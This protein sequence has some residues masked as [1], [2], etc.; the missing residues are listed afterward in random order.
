MLSTPG[1]MTAPAQQLGC[2]TALMIPL[3]TRACGLIMSAICA[4]KLGKLHCDYWCGHRICGYAI[5]AKRRVDL[6]SINMSTVV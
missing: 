5:N 3:R 6:F 2:V 1:M 4:R